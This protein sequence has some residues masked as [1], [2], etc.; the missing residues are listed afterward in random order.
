[1]FKFELA[2]DVLKSKKLTGAGKLAIAV[3]HR[4]QVDTGDTCNLSAKDIAD[5]IG[6]EKML[7]HRQ[8]QLAQELGFIQIKTGLSEKGVPKYFFQVILERKQE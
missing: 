8:M 2:P 4:M 7:V 3:V 1:M 6:V 5:M